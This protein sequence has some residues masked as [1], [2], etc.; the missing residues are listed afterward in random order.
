MRLLKNEERIVI[1]ASCTKDEIEDAISVLEA[2]L[3]NLPNRPCFPRS[4][5]IEMF[6]VHCRKRGFPKDF[7]GEL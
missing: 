3:E 1:E 4:K 6:L 5:P 2:L 7:C